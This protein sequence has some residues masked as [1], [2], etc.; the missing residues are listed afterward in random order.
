MRSE[1]AA[2]GKLTETQHRSH[3]GQGLDVSVKVQDVRQSEMAQVVAAKSELKTGA[4]LGFGSF[5]GALAAG[6]ELDECES[7]ARFGDEIGDVLQT[8]D[9]VGPIARDGRSDKARED[10][11]NGAPTWVWAAVAEQL[12]AADYDELV[13][14]S[15]GVQNGEIGYEALHRR[16]QQLMPVDFDD[17]IARDLTHALETVRPAVHCTPCLGAIDDLFRRLRASYG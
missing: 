13:G 14:L 10:L 1:L 6:A 12:D 16:L 15:V 2:L 3:L 8:L 4:L 9:D 7:F 5:L 11:V 17:M